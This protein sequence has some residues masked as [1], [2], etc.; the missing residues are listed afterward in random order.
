MGKEIFSDE[1]QSILDISLIKNE[2]YIKLVENNV[3]FSGEIKKIYE[4][5]VELRKSS[6][7]NKEIID[8]SYNDKEKLNIIS[9]L[10]NLD[11][12]VENLKV[13]AERKVKTEE[14]NQTESLE[15]LKDFVKN[16]SV[17]FK[18]NEEKVDFL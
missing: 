8:K 2:N 3:E 13:F 1:I 15:N 10:N 5:L 17:N 6:I 4:S 14:E 16:L 18:V 7:E 12:E 9:K 11:H